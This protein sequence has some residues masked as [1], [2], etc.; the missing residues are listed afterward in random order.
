MAEG[1]S[2][3][4][5]SEWVGRAEG[6]PPDLQGPWASREG[7]AVLLAGRLHR[8]GPLKALFCSRLSRWRHWLGERQVVPG[9]RITV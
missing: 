2:S 7:F 4:V 1:L 6:C 3:N 5:G 8:S 9:W